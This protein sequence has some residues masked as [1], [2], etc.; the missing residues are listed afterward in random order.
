MARSTAAP[1]RSPAAMA[2]RPAARAADS[3]AAASRSAA[4]SLTL[5]LES[6][7]PSASRT[8][9]QPTT[10]IGSDRSNAI[11]RT[12]ASCWKSFSPK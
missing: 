7:S 2:A 12:T 11:R 10:S 8:I 9:G 4:E 5:R 6:A 3:T 1:E